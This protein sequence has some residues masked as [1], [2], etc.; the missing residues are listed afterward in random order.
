MIRHARVRKLGKVVFVFNKWMIDRPVDD[1][2]FDNIARFLYIVL[3]DDRY[4]KR[5]KYS[6]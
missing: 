3:T 5:G 6:L 1:V 2:Y 4:N